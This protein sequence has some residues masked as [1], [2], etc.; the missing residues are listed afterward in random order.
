MATIF[1]L[2]QA[3]NQ[4]DL[5]PLP[6][7][8]APMSLGP[9]QPP[10]VPE[11]GGPS[12]VTEPPQAPFDPRIIA[13][14]LATQGPAPQAPAPRSKAE[15]I[16]N[17][18]AG[19]GAG[20]QGNGPQFLAQLQEPQRQYRAQLE[21]YNANRSELAAQGLGIAQRRQ[22]QQTRRAQEVADRQFEQEYQRESKR[23]G[24]SDQRELEMFRDTLLARRQREDDERAAKLQAQKDRAQQE[25]DARLF[26]SQLGRGP[27][28]APAKIAEELG[29]YYAKV[30]DRI[31]PAAEKWLNAQAKRAQILASRT[32]GGGT[33]GGVPAKAQKLADEIQSVK[34][35][36]VEAEARGDMQTVKQ[37][38][39]RAKALVR[40][41]GRFPEIEAGFDSSGK[42]PY[43][44][45]RGAAAPAAAPQG[46]NNDPLGIR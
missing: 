20:F 9:L 8:P 46:Q 18:L 22:E 44:K 6:A 42:W 7:P 1:D 25:R 35:K 12:Q 38:N 30:T 13:Q 28:A 32:P 5:P 3:L 41:A 34:N 17:A 26:A 29:N 14:L 2:L 4:G 45:A 16:F 23:L 15:R 10:N 11:Y 33:G 31:S 40:N 21:R 39:M 19:F 37:L 36:M 27:G 43:V 24:L